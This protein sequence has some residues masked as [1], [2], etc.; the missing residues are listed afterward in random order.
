V[1]NK[2]VQKKAVVKSLDESQLRNIV[3]NVMQHSR[4][5]A[6]QENSEND[7][8]GALHKDKMRRGPYAMQ[9]I[10]EMIDAFETI[11]GILS[12]YNNAPDDMREYIQ[13]CLERLYVHY[14]EAKEEYD[15]QNP[16]RYRYPR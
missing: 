7:W 8:Q 5:N 12:R 6:L 11:E 14:Q 2:N 16:R 13:K 4:G 3:R 9:D 10:S 1:R 15:K